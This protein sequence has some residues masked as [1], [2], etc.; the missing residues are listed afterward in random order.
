MKKILIIT[1]LALGISALR[2]TAEEAAPRRVPPS[3]RYDKNGDGMLSRDEWPFSAELFNKLDK[4]GNGFIDSDE[5]PGRCRGNRGKGGKGRGKG[6]PGSGGQGRGK[7][8]A[9]G[10]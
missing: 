4:D 7:A 8:A 9:R 10:Q 6:A 3:V 1:A 2:V 5:K